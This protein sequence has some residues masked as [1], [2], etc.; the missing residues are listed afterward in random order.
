MTGFGGKQTNL[1]GRKDSERGVSIEKHSLLRET[2]VGFLSDI[3]CSRI[4]QIKTILD[5]CRMSS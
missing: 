1:V 3:R 4:G 2:S 5:S